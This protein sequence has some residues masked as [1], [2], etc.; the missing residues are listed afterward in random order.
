MLAALTELTAEPFLIPPLAASMALVVGAPRLPLS[1]PRNVI[2]G[3]AVS[4]A[5]G[6]SIGAWLGDSL[7][8]GALAGA[9]ALG[10]MLVCRVPHSPAAAT[11]MIGVTTSV[12][13]WQFVLVVSAAAI[14]LVA[15]GVIGNKL[16]GAKYPV[17][18]W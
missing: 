10:A 5:V 9:L 11:G 1:Q 2:G 15:V 7:W 6:V 12:A 18:L 13:A 17:Y 8:F 3:Q 4:A 14:V 16:N